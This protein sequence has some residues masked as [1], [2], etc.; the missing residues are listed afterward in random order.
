MCDA[1][2][3]QRDLLLAGPEAAGYSTSGWHSPLVAAMIEREFGVRY[4]MG[5]LPAL[6]CGIGFSYQKAR[7]VSDHL[8]KELRQQWLTTTWPTI[9]ATTQKHGA[10][11]LFGYEAS[12]A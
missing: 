12:F 4:S 11:L 3:R 10:L 5:Y 9:V 7:F 2:F 8:N 6:L 1:V